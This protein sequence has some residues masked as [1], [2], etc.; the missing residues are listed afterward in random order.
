MMNR[1]ASFLV[2]ASVLGCASA[3]SRAPGA[4]PSGAPPVTSAPAGDLFARIP[5]EIGAFKLTERRAVSGAPTDSLFRFSDGSRTILTV[6]VYDVDADVKSDA[7]PQ[8]W[9]AAEGAKFKQVQDIRVSQGAISAYALAFS[10]T[11]RFAVGGH[12]IL[13]H[14]I[15]TS[16]R[17]PNGA[18]GVDMQYL[19]LIGGKFVKVRATVPESEWQHSKVPSFARDLARR[20]AGGP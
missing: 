20:I 16:T 3:P 19:Y 11:S 1:V 13:E 6:F 4:A 15:A 5:A 18:I 8:R 7:D 17:F 2:M 10:D 9:T 14:S 12:E